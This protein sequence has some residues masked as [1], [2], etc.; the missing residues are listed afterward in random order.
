MRVRFKKHK[1]PEDVTLMKVTT[2]Y[3]DRAR[4]L[5]DNCIHGSDPGAEYA[6]V[7]C[8]EQ[9]TWWV[10]GAILQHSQCRSFRHMTIVK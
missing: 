2:N 4:S 10:R 1:R 6:T 9:K 3:Y 8:H 5:C 7:W